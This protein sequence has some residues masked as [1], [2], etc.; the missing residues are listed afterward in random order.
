MHFLYIITNKNH[1]DIYYKET[2]T[3]QYRSFH[4][5]TPWHLK[6]AWIKVLFH[7]TNKICSSNQA[8]QQQLDHVK[9]L[10]SW[11]SYPEYVHNFIINRLKSNFN[12]NGNINSSKADRKVL[13]INLLY[14]E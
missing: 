2:H 14:L 8:F 13:W 1:T 7:R 3:E 4:S 12:R 10:M 9:T 5:Q 6:T 11:D